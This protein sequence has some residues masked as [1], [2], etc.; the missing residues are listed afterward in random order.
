[1]AKKKLTITLDARV[2]EG[3][4]AVIGRRRIS[5]FI[6]ILVRPHV[7][8]KSLDTA[9]RNMARDEALLERLRPRWGDLSIGIIIALI[10]LLCFWG[11]RSVLTPAG[12]ERQAWLFRIYLQ[13]G[14]SEQIQRSATL[15]LI[16]LAIAALEEIVWRGYVL[17][18]LKRRVGD[19][20]A[21]PIATLLYAAAAL[22]TVY[23]LRDPVAG[24]NPILVVAALGCGLF[25]SFGASMLR[26]LPPI[27]ISHM[28]FTYFTATQFRL[29]GL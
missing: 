6:E 28:V 18:E 4:H 3:L 23:T 9:Y 29:P 2:Y 13:L 15:T 1:M 8:G 22:P 20:S 19:R 25:W 17:D 14:S 5:R 7:P 16:I 10:L 24:L 12:S 11:G 26:R 21:W 27:M